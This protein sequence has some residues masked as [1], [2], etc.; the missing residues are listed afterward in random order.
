MA[1]M[2]A[3][4]VVAKAVAMEVL[5][6]AMTC[7]ADATMVQVEATREV[8]KV[9]GL[10]AVEYPAVAACGGGEGGGKLGEGGGGGWALAKA[11]VAS[12]KGM[13]RR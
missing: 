10:K 8:V 4:E 5:V 2:A 1:A 7:S 6:A 12:E 11:A 3:V 13:G 9:A